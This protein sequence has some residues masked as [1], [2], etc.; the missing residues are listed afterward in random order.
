MFPSPFES[1][2]QCWVGVPS[3]AQ[4]PAQRQKL[5]QLQASGCGATRGHPGPTLHLQPRLPHG[6]ARTVLG[7]AEVVPSILRTGVQNLQL[8]PG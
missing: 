6:A 2:R 8:S 4:S 3:W 1:H 7:D 5:Q